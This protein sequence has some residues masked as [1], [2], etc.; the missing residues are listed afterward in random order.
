M[1]ILAVCWTRHLLTS[2]P[3][4]L[5]IATYSIKWRRSELFADIFAKLTSGW[6]IVKLPAEYGCVQVNNWGKV[7]QKQ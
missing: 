2:E 5:E 3:D 4:S 1:I 6:I 7:W